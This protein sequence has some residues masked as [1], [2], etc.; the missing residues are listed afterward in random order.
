MDA[1]CAISRYCVIN[2]RYPVVLWFN[3]ESNK[4]SVEHKLYSQSDTCFGLHNYITIRP[5]IQDNDISSHFLALC[6]V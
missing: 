2:G 6:L 4:I 1:G 3:R 5:C